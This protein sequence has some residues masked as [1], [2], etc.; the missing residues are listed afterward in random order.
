MSRAAIDLLASALRRREGPIEDP[1][2]SST[3]RWCVAIRT[4]FRAGGRSTA[5]LDS[6]PRSL[7]DSAHSIKTPVKPVANWG[8]C[9][10]NGP[11][12]RPDLKLGGKSDE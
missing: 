8:G 7:I 4:R 11:R 9:A 10:W 2:G 3:L 1:T 5:S 12:H 6:A